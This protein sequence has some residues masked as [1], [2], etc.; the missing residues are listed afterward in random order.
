MNEAV[1]LREKAIGRSHP[2]AISSIDTL[3]SWQKQRREREAQAEEGDTLELLN[4]YSDDAPQTTCDQESNAWITDDEISDSELPQSETEIQ[5]T[6][7]PRHGSRTLSNRRMRES[8][9][10]GRL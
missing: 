5:K 9:G 10:G 7:R 1:E 2:F 3:A 4:L 8:E 6:K